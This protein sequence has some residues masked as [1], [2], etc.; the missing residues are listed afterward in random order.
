[1]ETRTLI[2]RLLAFMVVA[3][4]CAVTALGQ[5]PGRDNINALLLVDD[6]YGSSLNIDDNQNNILENFEE[7]G[8]EVTIASCTPEV[9]P[10]PWGMMQGCQ[11]VEPDIMTYQLDNALAWD[12]IVVIPGGSHQHLLDCP[13]VA[14]VISQ[15]NAYNIPIAAWCRGVRVLAAADVL[16]DVEITGH[17]D[18]VDEYLDAGAIYLG[19][20]EE[21]TIDG[22]IITCVSSSEYRQEMCELIREA[23][24]NT[25]STREDLANKNSRMNIKLFPNPIRTSSTLEF[26][27]D[28]PCIV[29][30]VLYDQNGNQVLDVVKQQF[31]QGSNRV[32]F[33]PAALPTGVYYV[34]LITPECVGMKKCMVI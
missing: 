2:N 15:A 23:V 34:Y 4:I 33:S 20:F 25:V 3:A 16:Q 31:E 17:I 9:N 13:F 24:D 26:E 28:D 30:I 22:N 7:Y 18:Y 14:N 11:S 19:N 29:H 12:V 6:L 27:L 5:S 8:W 1:M 32:N 21:P 10:C